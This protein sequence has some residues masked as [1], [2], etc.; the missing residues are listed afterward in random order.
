MY[1]KYIYIHIV[2]LYYIKNTNIGIWVQCRKED[3][4]LRLDL[5]SYGV[6][7]KL[8][9]FSWWLWDPGASP[10]LHMWECYGQSNV[11]TEVLR[12]I[13]ICELGSLLGSIGF[14]VFD[15]FFWDF[16]WEICCPFQ[17]SNPSLMQALYT[18]VYSGLYY[19]ALLFIII[20]FILCWFIYLFH[21]AFS[22]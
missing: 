11:M 3:K 18:F 22:T 7:F 10:H 6:I 12:R 14:Q 16:I 15:Y 5:N 9:T 1:I 20:L 4:I 19:H 2:I 8:L 13:Y 21:S 17:W